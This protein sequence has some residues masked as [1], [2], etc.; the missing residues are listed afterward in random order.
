MR[1]LPVVLAALLLA[2]VASLAE[3]PLDIR[4]CGADGGMSLTMEQDIHVREHRSVAGRTLSLDLGLTT[5][6]EPTGIEVTV[7]QAKATYTAHGMEQR[8]G[9]RQVIGRGIPLQISPEGRR[10]ELVPLT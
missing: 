9:T 1:Q 2:P 6:S 8:L 5:T 10:L 4:Y 7:E 3:E